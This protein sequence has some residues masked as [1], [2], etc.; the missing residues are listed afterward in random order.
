MGGFSLLVVAVALAGCGGQTVARAQPLGDAGHETGV[1]DASAG[2]NVDLTQP[3]S[4]CPAPWVIGPGFSPG[5]PSCKSGSAYVGLTCPALW[6]CT[7]QVIHIN[8]TCGPDP[9]PPDGMGSPIAWQYMGSSCPQFPPGMG[10]GVGSDAGSGSD[11]GP[12]KCVNFDPSKYDESCTQDSDCSWVLGSGEICSGQCNCLQT[13]L[14]T[15]ASVAYGAATSGFAHAQNCNCNPEFNPY[16]VNSKCVMC[17]P[18]CTPG[19]DGGCQRTGCG[20]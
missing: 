2:K 9:N 5:G 12:P 10:T 13:A 20:P 11:A 8:T 7:G 15:A 17:Q 1:S 16:C 18:T 3:S 6:Q 19:P 14:S 4:T